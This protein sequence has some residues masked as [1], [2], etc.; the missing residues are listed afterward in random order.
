MAPAVLNQ[1]RVLGSCVSRDAND[2]EDMF[3]FC[4]PAVCAS[5]GARDSTNTKGAASLGI[6]SWLLTSLTFGEICKG[7]ERG[8]NGVVC[9][10]CMYVHFELHRQAA[11]DGTEGISG[12]RGQRREDSPL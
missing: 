6:V 1:I 5:S 2:D 12:T 9:D 7:G 4:T 10:D 8:V 11:I 3:F